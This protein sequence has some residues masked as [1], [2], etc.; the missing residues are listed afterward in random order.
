VEQTDQYSFKDGPIDQSGPPQRKGNMTASF[1]RL[2]REASLGEEMELPTTRRGAVDYLELEVRAEEGRV[3]RA[4][5]PRSAQ[6][7]LREGVVSL[8]LPVAK[9][10][11]ECALNGMG[12]GEGRGGKSHTRREKSNRLTVL[13][14]AKRQK[15]KLMNEGKSAPEA[16]K[17]AIERASQTA[18]DR[19]GLNSSASYLKR[20]LGW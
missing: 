16:K 15:K 10:L 3:S 5:R 4:L 2:V 9:H 14:W 7:D 20:Q 1:N 17:L 8:P 6:A 11:L 19:F 12:K 18:H 13:N